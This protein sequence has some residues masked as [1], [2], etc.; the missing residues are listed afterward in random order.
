[1]AVTDPSSADVSGDLGRQDRLGLPT[2][3]M[4]EN[5]MTGRRVTP[6]R[7]GT[8]GTTEVST[9]TFVP[10]SPCASVAYLLVFVVPGPR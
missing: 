2:T 10:E 7:R 5:S 9:P 8:P 3:G 1:M 4:L 6:E